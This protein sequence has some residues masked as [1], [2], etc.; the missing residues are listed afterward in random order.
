[1][2]PLTDL[3]TDLQA[4][5]KWF[6]AGARPEDCGHGIR[7]WASSFLGALVD[8]QAIIPEPHTDAPRVLALALTHHVR[9]PGH[10]VAWLN[11]GLALRRIATSDPDSL[12]SWRLERALECF[13]R[14]LAL[15][16]TERPVSI[17]AWAGKALAFW[18]LRRFDEAVRVRM[19]PSNWIGLI[20]TCGSFA[21]LAS[22]LPA[23]GTR[24]H[25]LL[26]KHTK[27]T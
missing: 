20:R 11:V 23:R 9:N 15:S 17:R 4:L 7:D 8:D 14:S 26:K 3:P 13:D 5:L 1:M 22:R 27:H 18:Q 16:Q 19:R 25:G 12:R 2:S 10:C 24:C 21:R 6:D